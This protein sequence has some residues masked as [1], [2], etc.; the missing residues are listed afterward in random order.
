M[1]VV[2]GG[3]LASFVGFVAV[4]RGLKGAVEVAVELSEALKP[5]LKASAYFTIAALLITWITLEVKA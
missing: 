4:V 2:T 5:V 1:A 3:A